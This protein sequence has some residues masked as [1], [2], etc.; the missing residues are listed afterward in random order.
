MSRDPVCHDDTVLVVV[1]HD[2]DAL[3]VLGRERRPIGSF[4]R[5]H[6]A[7]PTDMVSPAH[8]LTPREVRLVFAREDALHP[9]RRSRTFMKI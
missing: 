5:E 6:A 8:F 9:R 7:Y 1:R 4:D 2:D 3:P